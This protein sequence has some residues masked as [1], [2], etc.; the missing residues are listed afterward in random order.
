MGCV[1]KPPARRSP[2]L[3]SI[4]PPHHPPPPTPTRTI[5]VARS[6]ASAKARLPFLQ[7]SVARTG[8]AAPVGGG[9]TG[10][11]LAAASGFSGAGSARVVP[12]GAGVVAGVGDTGS[13]DYADGNEEGMTTGAAGKAGQRG[14]A[15]GR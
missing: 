14:G 3:T 6:E 5:C 10:G 15:G 11:A 12:L 1:A 4:P 13:L 8:G 2:P 7:R 9:E